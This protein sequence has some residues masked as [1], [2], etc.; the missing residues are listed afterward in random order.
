MTKEGVGDPDPQKSDQKAL[1]AEA[2]GLIRR[3]V[4]ASLATTGSP[5]DAPTEGWPANALVT[6]ASAPDGSPILL[7]SMLAHHT[8]N[9]LADPRASLLIEATIL[10]NELAKTSR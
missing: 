6:V 10:A 7:L 4:K 9:L 5:Q 2:R 8:R 3:A 1:G